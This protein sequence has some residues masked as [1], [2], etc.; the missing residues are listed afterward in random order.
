MRT[1]KILIVLGFCACSV[2]AWADARFPYTAPCKQF[3]LKRPGA[4]QESA[5]AGIAERKQYELRGMRLH[6]EGRWKDSNCFLIHAL[7]VS[8]DHA[9]NLINVVGFNY[10]AL[11]ND[12]EALKYFEEATGVTFDLD[13]WLRYKKKP[14]FNTILNKPVY[15]KHEQALY[16]YYKHMGLPIP[17]Y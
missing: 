13:T 8:S 11:D 6:D 2:L 9:V 7:N 17:R 16:E 15:R 4:S 12:T 14:P 10:A 1:A 3:G 5:A